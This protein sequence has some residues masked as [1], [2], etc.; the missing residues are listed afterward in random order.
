MA[1]TAVQERG[2][3][4]ANRRWWHL[5]WWRAGGSHAVSEV[6]PSAELVANSRI[7]PEQLLGKLG[8]SLDGLSEAEVADRLARIGPNQIARE[9]PQTIPRELAGRAKNSL[10]G[11]LLS[12][13]LVSWLTGDARAAIVITLM[14]VLSVGL[15]FLQEHR[16]NRAAAELRALVKTT[17]TVRRNSPG[18]GSH[19]HEV[20]IDQLVPGD[21]VQLSAGD[22]VPADLRLLTTK[23]LHVDQAAL[24]GEAMPVDK[25]ESMPPATV[26]DPFD[27]TNLCFMGS[28]VLSGTATGVVLQT[29]GR[30]YFGRLADSIVGQRTQT[31]FDKGITRFTWLMIRFIVRD[32]ARGLPDQ[33][34]D[35]GRLAGSPTV[36]RRRRRGADARNAADDR[37]REPGEGRHR[38]G[39]Q[40]GHR[41]AAERDPEFRRD[42]RAVHRQDRHAD[43][44]P[45]HSAISPGLRGR[46]I[47][48]R[49]GIRLSEQPLPVRPEEP[50]GRGGVAHAQRPEHAPRRRRAIR[51]V[52]EIPFDFQRRRMSVVLD[53]GDGKHLLIAKGAV[54]EIFAICDALCAG[55]FG[56]PL[57]ATHFADA[58]REMEK[59]NAEGFRVVAVA[60]K[61]IAE[62]QAQL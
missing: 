62:P 13:A 33:R 26:T 44:G 5:R 54:E 6:A 25:H 19:A 53:R 20:P 43:A 12:L 4:T 39:A 27:L 49:P 51:K 28:N 21:I 56:R 58:K 29:G 17:A 60:F 1:G 61:E 9:R 8:T 23:D 34:P 2:G 48:A 31:D 10:N 22:L 57:D 40:A 36:R 47:R 18:D 55:R 11:L 32:G 59:L 3:P 38:D 42:G 45:H 35:Q 7:A 46:R 50:V 30:T 37:D 52:D 16:S 14:V 24:T 41:Q 15:A